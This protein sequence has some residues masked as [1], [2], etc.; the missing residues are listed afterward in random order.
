M[1]DFNTTYNRNV[2]VH[3][4]VP[5]V[6][7]SQSLG[8]E[9]P[10]K[11][12]AVMELPMLGNTARNFIVSGFL[13]Q[14]AACVAA[15]N[16]T[17][18]PVGEPALPTPSV[19][20]AP[21][22]KAD[23]LFFNPSS[24]SQGGGF[25]ETAARAVANLVSS[26]FA[27]PTRRAPPAN[28]LVGVLMRLM[29]LDSSKLSAIAV[30]ALIFMAQMLGSSLSVKSWD[31]KERDEIPPPGTPLGWIFDN[32]PVEA[33][34]LVHAAEDSTL[35]NQLIEIVRLGTTEATDCIEL[36]I[37]YSAPVV[38]SMQR[39]LYKP[40]DPTWASMTPLQRMFAYFPT[41]KEII[42]NSEGCDIQFPACKDRY[43]NQ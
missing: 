31:E 11:N 40:P 22:P 6:D 32:S 30:N 10:T 20:G 23:A 33:R 28:D 15:G 21:T 4:E 39:Y 42:H 12:I 25:L 29:G 9:L 7:T 2:I 17:E 18:V 36:L 14:F 8:D 34:D 19:E 26:N 24:H 27:P 1:E 3:D 35:P 5:S 13:V 37:C 16:T 38:W 41:F 43:V